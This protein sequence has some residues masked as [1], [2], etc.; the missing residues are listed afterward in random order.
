MR[1]KK[2]TNFHVFVLSNWAMFSLRSRKCHFGEQERTGNRGDFRFGISFSVAL[3]HECE[4]VYL[5]TR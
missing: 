3:K 2:E 5:R 4:D 1:G